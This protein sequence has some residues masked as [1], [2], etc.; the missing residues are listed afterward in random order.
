MVSHMPMADVTV[1]LPCS[2]MKC[3]DV[4]HRSTL[5]LEL[6]GELSG[7]DW[8]TFALLAAAGA[9]LFVPPGVLPGAWDYY[10]VS[11]KDRES[12]AYSKDD[13]VLGRKL[14][15]GGF[16]T[17][18]RGDL[19][20]ADGSVVPVIVKKAKEFGQAEAY[21]NERMSRVGGKHCAEF[22]TAFDERFMESPADVARAGAK[23]QR[24]ASA[25]PSPLDDA[26][27]LVW[28]YEGDNTLYDLMEDVREFP[29][30]L[31][32]LLLERQLQVPRGP[33]R[34]LA[35]IKLVMKQ[36]LEALAA[37]HAT[38]IV[39]RDVKPQNC[40]VSDR[41][42]KLKLIDLGAA[43]DLR[44]GINYVPNEYLLDPRYAPP[45]QYVMSTQTPRPPPKPV[46]AFLSPVL[47]RM[48]NPDRFD[49][50]SCGVTLLQMAFPA[51]RSDNAI[52][53]FNR[54][55]EALNWDLRRWRLEEEGKKGFA[56]G[57]ELLDLDDGAGWELL[58]SLMAYKPTDRLTA[59]GALASPFFNE[60]FQ[61]AKQSAK[62][63]GNAARSL[64]P[65]SEVMDAFSATVT[66]QSRG[67]LTEAQL[68][69]ELGL[70]EKA[71]VAPRG[72]SNTITWWEERQTDLKRSIE[73]RAGSSSGSGSGST[74]VKTNGASGSAA[75]KKAAKAQFQFS[76]DDANGKSVSNEN[77]SVN[78][79]GKG[80]SGSGIKIAGLLA[81]LSLGGIVGRGAAAEEEEEEDVYGEEYEE[82]QEE[83]KEVVMAGQKL[84]GF[85]IM[86]LLKR[87]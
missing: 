80:K 41:D 58:C 43:A 54:R 51:L 37:A 9:Y 61:P 12:R 66:G 6:R 52:I 55:L 64:L 70:E 68:K 29:Y 60:N 27:W 35:T 62:A 2:M 16:G 3:G 17:V 50:Y 25:A 79:N 14:A 59:A 83:E 85:D 69:Q 57:F 8:R 7:P 75:I 19:T 28:M 42:K 22:V 47:W 63:L 26:V 86:G 15:T 34:K 13:I 82:E 71:P 38:G 5:D 39:H 30:N 49:M 74:R 40:I 4:L 53:A 48:E 78:G 73:K 46:A 56:E 44:V 36:L 87:K 21:M 84:G 20:T 24:K 76:V 18:Y 45:Q 81:G 33:R 72:A 10:V 1:A 67:S 32:P 11:K 77:E 31:E 23:A 65:S